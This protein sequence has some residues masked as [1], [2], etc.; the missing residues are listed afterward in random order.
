MRL[1]NTIYASMPIGLISKARPIAKPVLALLDRFI[2]YGRRGGDHCIYKGALHIHTHFSDGAMSPQEVVDVAHRCGFDFI[3]ITDH[4]TVE[5]AL[6]A[7]EY[8]E[9]YPLVI[10]GQ[11]VSSTVGH[12]GAYG[13]RESITDIL[14]ADEVI[15]EI[16]EQG[17]LAV[18]CHPWWCWDA[19]LD[20]D[21]QFDAFE[22]INSQTHPYLW[23]PP[24]SWERYS[25][26]GACD[27]H[28]LSDIGSVQNYVFAPSLN[29][30]DILNSIKGGRLIISGEGMLIAGKGIKP[31]EAV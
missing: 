30:S 8:A 13:I 12:I 15:K 3:V 25:A 21:L 28:W 2:V 17:G 27:A 5:G 4:G 9:D 11:E 23:R 22:I 19:P 6:I 16:H 14:P 18:L 1:V 10:V 29:T 26:V 31:W 24:Q 20:A 7:K